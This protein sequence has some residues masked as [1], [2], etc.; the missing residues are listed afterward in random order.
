VRVRY[1]D[2][3]RMGIVHHARFLEYLE[4]GRVELMRDTGLSYRELE[5]RGILYPVIEV[6]V[7]YRRSLTF[8]DLIT[9]ET[10]YRALERTRVTFGYR[11]LSPAGEVAADAL[12][13]HAQTD[14]SGKP[15][16]ISDEIAARVRPH[17]IPEEPARGRLRGK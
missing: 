16:A 5:E 15:V 14:P 12:T 17:V 7:R 11:L 8:D 10:W 1:A 6:W 9:V 13:L 3:D 4:M 2:T